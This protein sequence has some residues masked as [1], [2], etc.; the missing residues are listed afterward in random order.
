[1]SLSF[2]RYNALMPM[3]V[4]AV[5]AVVIV[6]VVAVDIRGVRV[7][8]DGFDSCSVRCNRNVSHKCRFR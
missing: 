8:V 3:L 1:M 2:N 5:V 4:A 6:V 7:G